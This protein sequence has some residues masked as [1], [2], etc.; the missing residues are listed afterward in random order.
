MVHRLHLS[1][2]HTMVCVRVSFALFVHAHRLFFFPCHHGCY[3]S[4]YAMQ[5]TK[6]TVCATFNAI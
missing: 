1:F 6:K 5:K 4:E 3:P 2:V